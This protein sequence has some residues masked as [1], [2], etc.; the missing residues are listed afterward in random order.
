MLAGCGEAD[1]TD[2]GADSPPFDG[3]SPL[4]PPGRETRVLVQLR[5]PALAELGYPPPRQRAYVSSLRNEVRALRSALQA[6]GV[7]L[8]K[9]V[10]F[11]RVW[12]GFAAPVDTP[13]RPEIRAIG[14]RA[15][16]VRRFYSAATAAGGQGAGDRGQGRPSV[17]LL[18]SS[19]RDGAAL[20]QVLAQ[21]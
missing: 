3:R 9:P 5:R 2:T 13:D 19:G 12:N 20:A 1:V 15:E 10:V 16:P 18:S 17:A 11:A 6:K 8:R 4:V 21:T 14:L 7:A